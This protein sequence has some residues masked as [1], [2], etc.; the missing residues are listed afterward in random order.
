MAKLWHLRPCFLLEIRLNT[1][2]MWVIYLST[3]LG[4]HRS[5]IAKMGNGLLSQ[6][7]Q[8]CGR[9]FLLAS[10]EFVV[11][12]N[13]LAKILFIRKTCPCSEYPLKPLFYIEKQGLAAVY[14]ISLFFF[15]Q[16]I[17]CGYSLELPWQ[18]GSNLYPH[19]MFWAKI[20]K[21]YKKILLN[22]I[23]PFFT[24]EKNLHIAWANFCYVFQKEVIDTRNILP[25][26]LKKSLPAVL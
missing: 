22:E 20:F 10:L 8:V 18:G 15:I 24:T 7:A 25:Y 21:I 11:K 16:N 13:T 3:V 17:D 19:S 6:H 12:E 14:L 5:Y 1:C 26:F 4:L 9:M 2:A 23:Y